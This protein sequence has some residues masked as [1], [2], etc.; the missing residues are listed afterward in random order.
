MHPDELNLRQAI[1]A[2]A[3]RSREDGGREALHLRGRLARFLRDAGPERYTEAEAEYDGW[4]KGLHAYGGS[5]GGGGRQLSPEDKKLLNQELA[6]CVSE[7]MDIREHQGEDVEDLMW[8][9]M[10]VSKRVYGPNSKEVADHSDRFGRYLSKKQSYGQAEQLLKKALVMKER[11]LGRDHPE[12]AGI[13]RAIGRVLFEVNALKD[14]GDAFDKALTID[15]RHGETPANMI[16]D[17]RSLGM[18]YCR[19]GHYDKGESM[20][21][22]VVDM[23][24]K[25]RGGEEDPSVITEMNVLAVLLYAQGKMD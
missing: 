13:L 5:G 15:S 16:E 17:M 24:K 1:N 6:E 22:K 14:A 25:L 23:D 8:E 12:I 20:Y 21:R 10:S 18:V 9:L 11:S 19:Q 2:A 3:A 7:Y 4:M